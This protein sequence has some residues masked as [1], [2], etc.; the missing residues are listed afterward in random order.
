MTEQRAETHAGIAAV[1]AGMELA[2]HRVGAADVTSK[3]KL[4][5]VTATDVAV[6]DLIRSS[7]AGATG[8]PV[9]G[10]ERGGDAPPAGSPYWLLDPICG[11]RNFASDIPLYCVNLALVED[12][13]VT[14]GIVGNPSTGEIGVAERGSGGWAGTDG[15]ARRLAASD[16]SETV[17]IEPGRA[18]GRRRED[19]A[20][21]TAAAIGADRWELRNLSTTLTLAYVATGRVAAYVV[22]CGSALHTAAGSLLAAEAGA[23]V[24]DVDGRPWTIASDSIVAAATP[25]LHSELLGLR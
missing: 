4:D 15:G 19:A 5:V 17:V 22:F 16:A 20:R 3:G 13:E 2:A 1:A 6:E 9:T 21:F 23:V 18:T 24:S 11:T 12:G 8:L 10:E 14:I 7:V 25:E